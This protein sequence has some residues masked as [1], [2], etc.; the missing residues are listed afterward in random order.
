[1]ISLPQVLS[2]SKI[3]VN[4]G[5]FIFRLGYLCIVKNEIM[6][7]TT[8][9]EHI[10]QWVEATSRTW[11]E[12][13]YAA[14]THAITDTVACMIS[15][16][17]DDAA[18]NVRKTIKSWSVDTGGATIVGTAI[19]APAPLAAFANG[20]S[21]HAQD[22]DDNFLAALT[23]ASAVL[24]PALMALGEQEGASGS[25]IIDAYLAGLECHAAI[26]RGV[27][28]SHYLKGFHAT[29]TVGCIGTAAACARLLQLE[30]HQIMHAMSLGTS[31]AAGLKGQFGSH[32]KPFQAGM[33]AQNGVL[34]ACFARDGVKGRSEILDND[35]GFLKLFGGDH[36]PGWD[37]TKYPLGEPHVI[38]SVGLAPK[39]HPC[40][41]ST[42]KSL[43]NL[44]ELKARYNLEPEDV[45][46]MDTFVNASNVRNLCFDAP[47]N[48]M[49]AR[50]SMQYCMA[51]A[52]K[53][54]FLSLQ[55]FTP[56]AVQRPEIRALIPLTTMDSTPPEAELNPTSEYTHELTVTLKSGEV[57]KTSR[58]A[59]KGTLGDPLTE[60]ER[61]RKFDDCCI[62]ILGEPATANLYSNCNDLRGCTNLQLLLAG[63]VKNDIEYTNVA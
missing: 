3:V 46:S 30:R 6:G 1:M 34:A 35:Y 40:C 47:Q 18:I 52:L 41:G 28:R 8:T 10:A 27:N 5:L 15:G 44:L 42:H 62:P 59:A 2:A 51:V 54:G 21:A 61:R 57:L 19:R 23:H 36:A 31:M 58:T 32:A 14:A 29:A 48:E 60:N 26:G 63:M 45:E 20:T 38:Q 53:N 43:D 16:A 37:F 17:T 12:E 7:Q 50:F 25:D 55:D 24:V 39:I 56:E 9:L 22:F 13:F 49:E 33:A 11:P 4:F